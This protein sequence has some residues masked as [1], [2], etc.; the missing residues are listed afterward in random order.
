MH[1]LKD[2]VSIQVTLFFITIIT[3]SFVIVV[4]V[5]IILGL[6]SSC[7]HNVTDTEKQV[8]SFS[9]DLVTEDDFRIFKYRTVSKIFPAVLEKIDR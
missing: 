3:V 6:D 4:V 9:E 7:V 1:F 2:I 8:V 5:I